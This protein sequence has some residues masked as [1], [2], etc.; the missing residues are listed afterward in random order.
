MHLIKWRCEN[1]TMKRI[2][3][4]VGIL[5][6]QSQLFW[7][8]KGAHLLRGENKLSNNKIIQYASGS[9]PDAIFFMKFLEVLRQT[10]QSM[11]ALNYE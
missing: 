2:K 4:F 6:R 5:E 8:S 3:I 9:K 11:L 7:A 1:G 10:R